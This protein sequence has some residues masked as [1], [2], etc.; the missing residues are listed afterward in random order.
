MMRS[1]AIR[2]PLTDAIEFNPAGWDASLERRGSP[3][4]ALHWTVYLTWSGTGH[5]LRTET[6]DISKD[7]FY[8]LLDQPIRPGER[9][10]CDIV[11]PTHHSEDPDDVVCLRCRA[12]A[13]R[14]EKI[15]TGAE[16]G[17]AC[18]IE[19]Y[20]IIHGTNKSP[21]PAKRSLRP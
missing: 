2:D 5:P 18:R 7:G 4:A 13:V 19:D 12:Q 17:L 10:Q 20:R 15:G 16:F 6:S 14:V 9:I 1:A 3:R 11:L 8:C 21:A